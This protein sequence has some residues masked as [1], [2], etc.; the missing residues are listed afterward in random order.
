M[1]LAR[2]TRPKDSGRIDMAK[3]VA[4]IAS[5]ETE[6]RALPHLVGHL[7]EQGIS[8]VDVRIPPRG[9][10][11]RAEM[12]EKLIKATWFADSDAPPEK[13]VVVVDTDQ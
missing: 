10:P 3:R 13:F 5:G 1:A 4:V 6:R 11:L 12:V 8:L 2:S 9:L 7:Q